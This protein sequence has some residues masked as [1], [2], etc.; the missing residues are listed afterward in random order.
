MNFL[1]RMDQNVS[2]NE[3]FSLLEERLESIYV[4]FRCSENS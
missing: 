2:A 1:K 4:F 3:R